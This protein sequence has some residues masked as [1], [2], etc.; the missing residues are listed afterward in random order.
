MIDTQS[1]IRLLD[2]IIPSTTSLAKRSPSSLLNKRISPCD[3]HQILRVSVVVYHVEL[4]A[5]ALCFLN[6]PPTVHCILYTDIQTCSSSPPCSSPS[7]SSMVFQSYCVIMEW[8][9][10]TK[11]GWSRVRVDHVKVVAVIEGGL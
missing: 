11:C 4:R 7:A 9:V 10:L 1:D 8:M 2:C 6:F 5:F 3:W